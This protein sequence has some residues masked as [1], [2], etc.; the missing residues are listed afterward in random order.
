VLSG[1]AVSGS[2]N[3][4]SAETIFVIED[5]P[6]M[7][8]TMSKAL[9]A[10]GFRVLIAPTGADARTLF[11]EGQP[12]LIILDLMLP[13]DDGLAMTTSLRRLTK[14]P[15]VVCSARDGQID[16]VLSSKLGAADFIAKPFELE[17]LEKR[18][19][20]ALRHPHQAN[21]PPA[22]NKILVWR[23]RHRAKRRMM[24]PSP[25]NGH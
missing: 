8:R 16:R 15:I 10:N 2:V 13:D 20:A 24:G 25:N 11:D 9:A 23:Q 3:K 14:A 4:A 7:S 6:D 1:A 5:D 19:Q 21:G 22:A 18:I 17:D 12:D